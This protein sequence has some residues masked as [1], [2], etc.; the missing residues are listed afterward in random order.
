[1]HPSVFEEVLERRRGLSTAIPER[2]IGLQ[3]DTSRLRPEELDSL[4][5]LDSEESEQF[6][7]AM[8]RVHERFG[9]KILGGCCGTDHRHIESIAKKLR[10]R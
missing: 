3:A 6:A 5:F 7:A 4:D 9:I 2:I 1:M 10:G 8:L